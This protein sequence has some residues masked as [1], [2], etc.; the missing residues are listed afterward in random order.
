LAFILNI[1]S[2]ARNCS[3]SLQEDELLLVCYDSYIDKSASS[4]INMFAERAL[5]DCGISFSSLDAIS[6]GI[7]PGSY[8][9]LRIAVSTAKGFALALDKPLIS[10]N[11]L[12]A[13][14]YTQKDMCSQLNA[15]VCPMIDARRMEVFCAVYDGSL[16]TIVDT[17]AK[18]LE[19][20]SFEEI[21]NHGKV[22][23][24]GDGSDK[25]SKIVD[26]S[27]ALFISNINP[28]ARHMYSMSYSKF[29]EGDIS[30]VAYLEPFYLKQ[31]VSTSKPK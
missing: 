18:V 21:L 6:V 2:S 13:M 15:L 26:S 12:E 22:I 8:T 1:D 28:S 10:I 17:N 3:V 31:F 11:T 4:I 9:G 29:L 14:A 5:A 20:K 23:F 25:F 27:N 16:N 7:G 30:D 24:I 19:P